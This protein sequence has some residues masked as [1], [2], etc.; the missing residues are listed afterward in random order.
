MV[1][2]GQGSPGCPEA[3]LWLTAIT[4]NTVI[5]SS[6]YGVLTLCQA[7]EWLPAASS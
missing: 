7:P 4:Q 6:L 3:R 5:S 2:V 1:T